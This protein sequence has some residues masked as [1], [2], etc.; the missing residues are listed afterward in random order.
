MINKRG[1]SPVIATVLLVVVA[2][3]LFSLIFI[4]I[5]S[6]QHEAITKQGTP[7]EMVCNDINFD[8]SYTTGT[9]QITNNGDI[10]IYKAEIYLVSPEKTKYYNS[11]GEISQTQSKMQ[12]IACNSWGMIKVI[13]VLIGTTKSGVQKEYTCENQFKIISCS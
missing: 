5:R 13:P 4:W 8:L 3:V 1:I 9:L 10:P 2:L 6:F 12:N 11:T 7:I